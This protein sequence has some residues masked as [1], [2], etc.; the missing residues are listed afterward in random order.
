MVA[1][2]VL[3]SRIRTAAQLLPLLGSPAVAAA[4]ASDSADIAGVTPRS[5]AAALAAGP[6]TP[7][8]YAAEAAGGEVCCV[9]APYI[10]VWA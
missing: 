2:V 8:R 7:R 10:C 6:G 5:T 3:A 4:A 1:T 9:C